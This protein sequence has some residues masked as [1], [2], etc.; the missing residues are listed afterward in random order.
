MSC[1]LSVGRTMVA[2]L[3]RT[4]AERRGIKASATSDIFRVLGP[5]ASPGH[6]SAPRERAEADPSTAGE[7]R[8]IAS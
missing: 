4:K 3:G 1:D 7:E 5:M 6:S 8:P 2:G